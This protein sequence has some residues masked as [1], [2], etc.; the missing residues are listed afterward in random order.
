MMPWLRKG[1]TERPGVSVTSSLSIGTPKEG[2]LGK[3]LNLPAERGI[4]S[5]FSRGL[6]NGMGV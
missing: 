4:P 5:D 1:I 2:H 3:S 6:S